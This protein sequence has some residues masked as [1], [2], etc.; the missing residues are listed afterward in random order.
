MNGDLL[1]SNIVIALFNQDAGV[2][3]RIAEAREIFVPSTVLGE[4]YFGAFKS[5]RVVENVGRVDEFAADN[6]IV[7][8]DSGTAKIYGQIRDFLRRK[9]RMIPGNDLWIAALAS[10]HDLTLITRDGHFREVE[11]LA[12]E[13]W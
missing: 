1:D 8:C 12:I 9:G 6:T 5:A 10:Q 4:L 13:A 7:E 11:G 2:M 3:Q